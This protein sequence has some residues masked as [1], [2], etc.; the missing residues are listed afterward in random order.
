MKTKLI[1]LVGAP[2]S[3]KSTWAKKMCKNPCYFRINRDLLRLMFKG[4]YVVNQD[5]EELITNL[6]A[7]LLRESSIQGRVVILD[8]TSCNLKRVKAF[9]NTYSVAFNIEYK[10]FPISPFRQYVR[11]IV[12]AIKTGIFIPHKVLEKMNKG[13]KEVFDY[14][15]KKSHV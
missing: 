14:L 7:Y 3:G 12:R 6:R 4:K 2:C 10:F 15:N 13:Y 1:L 11:N 8:E 9:I 5:V